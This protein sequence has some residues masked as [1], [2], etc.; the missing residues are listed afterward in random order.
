MNDIQHD[1]ERREERVEAVLIA[2]AALLM[3]CASILLIVFALIAWQERIDRSSDRAPA[4][5]TSPGVGEHGARPIE[6]RLRDLL[7][8]RRR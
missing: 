8:D 6:Q 7:V 2:G 4:F 5:A 1:E 3:L